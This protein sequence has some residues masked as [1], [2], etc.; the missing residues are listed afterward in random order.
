M[1]FDSVDTTLLFAGLGM[2]A[3]L[4]G[5]LAWRRVYRVLP[6]FFVFILWSSAIDFATLLIVRTITPVGYFSRW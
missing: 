5:L 6:V 2:D 4:I 3:T 1:T